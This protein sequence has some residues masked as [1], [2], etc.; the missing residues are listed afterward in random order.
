MKTFDAQCFCS[1]FA[2]LFLKSHARVLACSP[3]SAGT[4][5]HICEQAQFAVASA[6]GRDYLRYLGVDN[7]ALITCWKGTLL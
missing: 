3:A 6:F 4:I 1:C 7:M 2:R 5:A